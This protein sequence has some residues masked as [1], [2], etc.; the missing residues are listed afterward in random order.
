MT[1][2]EC[3]SLLYGT[4]LLKEFPLQIGD[5]IIHPIEGR[6]TRDYDFA[7]ITSI[8]KDECTFGYVLKDGEL[9]FSIDNNNNLM[10]HKLSHCA[11]DFMNPRML[12]RVLGL[13]EEKGY[14][15]II[16]PPNDDE[17]CYTS[18]LTKDWNTNDM[19]N[20]VYDKSFNGSTRSEAAVRALL[21]VYDIEE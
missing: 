8:N 16:F 15:L 3:F 10:W 1:P 12:D 13:I 17:R 20:S 7:L 11:P 9:F 4:E 19:I 6:W 21:H 14:A 5:Y 18:F 2:Q